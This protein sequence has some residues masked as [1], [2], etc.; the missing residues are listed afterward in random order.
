MG[1][2]LGLGAMWIS[3]LFVEA[4]AGVPDFDDLPWI[5]G[6]ATV[7]FVGVSL[8]L[9]N[10]RHY[11]LSNLFYLLTDRRAIVC[12]HALNWRFAP[13]FYVV[14]CPHSATYPY[15]VISSRPYPSLRV[16]AMLSVNSVQPFGI[17]LSHPGHPVMWG[18]L[19]APVVFDYVPD[20][21]ELLETILSLAQ[22]TTQQGNP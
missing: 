17:G 22:E 16:G 9:A 3:A 10:Q 8:Y 6:A 19:T 13:R 5:F 2:A 20:A 21:E 1:L 15:Q 7:G 4:G 12:R 14:S 18:R 11:V